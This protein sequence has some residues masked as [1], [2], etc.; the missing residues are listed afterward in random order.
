MH[1][2]MIHDA[3]ERLYNRV[4]LETIE[5]RCKKNPIEETDRTTLYITDPLD[6]PIHVQLWE[7]TP[8]IDPTYA[9]YIS[10]YFL[11]QKI[12]KTLLDTKIGD[13]IIFSGTSM[14][15][16]HIPFEERNRKSFY[17]IDGT[18]VPR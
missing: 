8:G 3:R 18:I 13:S 17:A 6:G 10:V 12:L 5:I 14:P 4:V 16:E 9:G 11:N 15:D 7:F 1:H 2:S